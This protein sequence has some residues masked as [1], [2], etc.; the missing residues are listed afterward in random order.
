MRTFSRPSP[1][2]SLRPRASQIIWKLSLMLSSLPHHNSE[3]IPATAQPSHSRGQGKPLRLFSSLLW[4]E[5]LGCS[6]R[7]GRFFSPPG[8]TSQPPA[9]APGLGLGCA[10]LVPRKGPFERFKSIFGYK[11]SGLENPRGRGILC[12]HANRSFFS[13]FADTCFLLRLIPASVEDAPS[14]TS[15]GGGQGTRW[16]PQEFPIS[17]QYISCKYTEPQGSWR[18]AGF[19]EA[20][21]SGP[22]SAW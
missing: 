14:P 22:R 11:A 4:E 15:W 21:S 5:R 1:S 3:F 2:S 7:Q 10:Q 8:W 16:L 19:S 17:W 12:P 18:Q 20:T 13:A 9:G 6:S